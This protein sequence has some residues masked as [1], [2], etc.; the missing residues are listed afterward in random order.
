MPNPYFRFKQF[1]IRHDRSAMKVGTDGVLLGAWASLCKK[2]SQSKTNILD[3]GT[4]TG[5]IALMLAQRFPMAVIEGVD[6]DDAS[7]E[8]AKENVK[9]SPFSL[10]ISIE[11]K[12]FNSIESF[13][14]KYDL[15]VSNPPFYQEDTLGGNHARDAARHTTSLPFETLIEN[16]SLLLTKQ[17]VFSVIL[18]SGEASHFI[19]ICATYGL[20]LEHRTDIQSTPQKLSKRV[21][22]AFMKDYH[23]TVAIDSLTLYDGQGNRTSE[24]NQLTEDFYLMDYQVIIDKYYPIDNE[25]KHILMQHSRQVADKALD[26]VD[27]HPELNADRQFVEEAAMLHDIGIFRC[28]AAGIQCFGTEPYIC[29][30][31]IGAQLLRA[32]GFPHHARVCERHTGAGLSLEEIIAQNL[33]VPHCDL[34]P[35]TI[36]EQIICY[37]DKFFS[38]TKLHTEKTLEQAIRS[39]SKFGEEGVARFVKWSEIFG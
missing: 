32:E 35:E 36:E 24:Y 17:G 6:I 19:A 31:T 14:N 4:G 16:A 15:I 29:H 3:I 2:A 13:S 30:G 21:L 38:K 20:Y 10:R 5:L 8:Q 11:K 22:L 34:L 27:K 39:L 7:I 28:D 33:P 1:T 18:P 9:S 37:A 25:L 12:D 23:F 26:I